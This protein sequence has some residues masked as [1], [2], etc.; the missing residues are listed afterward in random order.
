M[1]TGENKKKLVLNKISIAQLDSDKIK[2][3]KGGNVI[4]L[5]TKCVTC[6]GSICTITK[7]ILTTTLVC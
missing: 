1:K 4:S 2:E 5:I 6:Q 3:I 7:T